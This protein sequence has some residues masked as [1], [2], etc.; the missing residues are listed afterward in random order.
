MLDWL[1]HIKLIDFGLSKRLSSKESRTYSFVGSDGYMA[2]EVRSREPYGILA[3]IYSI[4]TLLYEMLHGYPPYTSYDPRTR[5]Y[6]YSSSVE[7]TFRKGL[8]IEVR[9]LMFYLIKK[10]PKSRL[11]EGKRTRD[12]LDHS[13]F[14]PIRNNLD[15]NIEL[16]PPFRPNFIADSEDFSKKQAKLDQILNDIMGS[17]I[18]S[19][20]L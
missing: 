18:S 3:D 4:G 12:L 5:N 20:G 8:S 1:G 13:W 7:L 14:F 6:R 9:D 11:E 16:E 19:R 10:D 17:S 2:P 15:N